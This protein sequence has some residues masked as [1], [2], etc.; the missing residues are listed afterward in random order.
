[1]L[2]RLMIPFAL[3]VVLAACTQPG[4]P[5]P[6]TVTVSP[7][8][9]ALDVPVDS[10]V[11]ATFSAPLNESTVDGAFA[12]TS[13]EGTVAGDIAYDASN[14]RI[15]FTPTDPLDYET[16]YT[17]MVAGT[18]RTSTGKKISTSGSYSWSFTTEAQSNGETPAVIAVTIN[19]D[20][21]GLLIG[22]T[23]QL[24]AD[25][26]ATGGA[27]ESVTWS[28]S[29]INIATVSDNGLVTGV[30]PGD[31]TITATSTF[32][33]TIR[34]TAAV[35][36][37]AAPTVVAVTIVPS[38]EEIQIGE[39]FQLEAE[40]TRSGDASQAVTW[41][42]LPPGIVSVNEDG[43]VTG[44][45]PG[46]ATVTATSDHD[47]SISGTAQITV[48]EPAINGV[49]VSPSE[50]TIDVGDDETLTATVD[51]ISL[52]SED[53]TW[54]STELLIASVDVD[55]VVTGIAPGTATITA[56]SNFDPTQSASATVNVAGVTSVVV[57]PASEAIAAGETVQLVADVTA[58][59]GASE[60]VTW[61]SSDETVATVDATGLVTAQS[62]GTADITAT[63]TVDSAITGSS[64]I[65]VYGPVTIT[66]HIPWDYEATGD[67]HPLGTAG[68]VAPY[69]YAFTVDAPAGWPEGYDG[70]PYNDI[71]EVGVLRLP[72]AEI[73]IDPVSNTIG[74][75]V[76]LEE[77]HGYYAFFVEVTDAE[78]QT[79]YALVELTIP[80]PTAP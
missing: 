22:G 70:V 17:A 5:T 43:L 37:T 41:S 3:L 67:G 80:N 2:R 52:A 14:R 75:T 51:A 29:D 11:T 7:A 69:D 79:D 38:E 19:P 8:A 72:P 49:T 26:D 15:T 42:S 54:T 66:H 65:T 71:G 31:V 6:V 24:R 44:V 32:D 40:V 56:T 1:M 57:D 9:G 53:V 55:G 58:L 23:E 77:D 63:S 60:D 4:Q 16:K 33:V 73:T 62:V 10:T 68:G 59:H 35:T 50:I 12:L 64:T 28:S 78:G 45:A 46:T 36:V 34:G 20:T 74:G 18:V 30:A 25:V 76:D 48:L 39:D 27:E 21:V 61:S 47:P 13:D